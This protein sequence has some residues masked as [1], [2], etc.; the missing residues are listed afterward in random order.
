M[1]GILEVNHKRTQ[2]DP[3]EEAHPASNTFDILFPS[4]FYLLDHRSSSNVLYLEWI[5]LPVCFC[6]YRWIISITLYNVSE[7]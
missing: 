6:S 5:N 4:A 3:C 7:F 1:R 2:G